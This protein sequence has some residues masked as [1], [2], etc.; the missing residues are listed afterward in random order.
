MFEIVLNVP[1]SR[2]SDSALG[3]SGVTYKHTCCDIL[4]GR[5]I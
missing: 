5:V 1:E 2:L 3:K 4:L